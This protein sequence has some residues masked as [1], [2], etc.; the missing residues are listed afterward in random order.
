MRKLLFCLL[1]LAWLIP[2]ST[3]Q[4][5]RRIKY[6]ADMGF[7]DEDYMPGAQRLIGNVAFAQDNV[8]GY[9]D[10]A[11]LFDADNYIIAFGDKVRIPFSMRNSSSM[12]LST[13]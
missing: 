13:N 12:R 4:E 9:C 6:R 1:L 3:A 7:Y 10:S 11:Y 5:G 2:Q 8:R